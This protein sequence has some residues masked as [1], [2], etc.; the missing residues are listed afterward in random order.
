VAPK[1][2]RVEAA[3]ARIGEGPRVTAAA[4]LA[5]A[6]TTPQNAF[7]AQLLERTLGSV[8]NQAKA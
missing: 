1:P 4:V 3:E 7:K 2:W 5:G 8:F 6:R